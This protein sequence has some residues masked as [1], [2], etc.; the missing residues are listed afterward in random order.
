[1]VTQRPVP[2]RRLLPP[3]GTS[4]L[5][6]PT[7]M[8]L[9]PTSS[10]QSET[11]GAAS[12]AT[13]GRG[14]RDGLDRAQATAEL[15]RQRALKAAADHGPTVKRQALLAI[16]VAGVAAR[17]SARHAARR[18]AEAALAAR[19]AWQGTEAAP[20]RRRSILL[21]G[22]GAVAVVLVLALMMAQHHAT[23][24]ARARVAGLLDRYELR[25]TVLY[26]DVSASPFGTVT[27]TGVTLRLDSATVPIDVVT[28]RDIVSGP[29][30]LTRA[31]VAVNG[32]TIP[33]VP[34]ARSE[35]LGFWPAVLL[36]L[37]VVHA[38]VAGSGSFAVDDRKEV[39]TASV[40]LDSA[41]V[42]G[43]SAAIRL[44]GVSSARLEEAIRL[45]QS[46]QAGSEYH[47]GFD[48]QRGE[49]QLEALVEG[50]SWQGGNLRL[51]DAPLRARARQVT[52]LS[53]P[54][55][56]GGG[57]TIGPVARLPQESFTEIMPGSDAERAR[58]IVQH[59][60]DA[61]GTLVVRSD[62]PTPVGLF[63]RDQMNSLVPTLSDRGTWADADITID[64]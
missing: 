4:R 62:P 46:L 54:A 18:S 61:G 60:L 16:D 36:G 39:L 35:A 59:W 57:G 14:A 41:G 10:G 51:N 55:E 22:A 28:L 25:R 64:D 21:G 2:A 13:A 40:A 20:G 11:R 58:R 3:P 33:V 63:R 34:L 5:L 29:D 50:V 23:A 15:L 53:T 6:A 26:R 12:G 17:E 49:Q 19:S 1:M 7:G 37:G 45:L 52:R 31:S 30:G 32:A 48:A 44:G 9:P 47:F 38:R 43:A 8:L 42:G 24:M 56:D 27:L